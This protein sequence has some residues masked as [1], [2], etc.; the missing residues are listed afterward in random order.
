MV[1]SR[2]AG[3]R[4][5]VYGIPEIGLP[6]PPIDQKTS[7]TPQP[8]GQTPCRQIHDEHQAEG[9]SRLSQIVKRRP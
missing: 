4:N 6:G 7:F 8:T 3:L 5:P 1:P 2:Q 9:A